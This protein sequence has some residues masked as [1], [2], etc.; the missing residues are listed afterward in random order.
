MF[1]DCSTVSLSSLVAVPVWPLEG[2]HVLLGGAREQ[3]TLVPPL[4]RAG[5]ALVR[6]GRRQLPKSKQ[7]AE[8]KQT[9]DLE[10]DLPESENCDDDIP[11]RLSVKLSAM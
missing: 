2:D 9:A 5:T 4:R 1:E 6:L 3:R 7:T 8:S 10:R 11:I